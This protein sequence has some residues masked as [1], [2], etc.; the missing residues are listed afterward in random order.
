M[1]KWNS[2]WTFSPSLWVKTR[3]EL[4]QGSILPST[5]LCALKLREGSFLIKPVFQYEIRT[6]V[7][8]RKIAKPIKLLLNLDRI[9]SLLE[10]VVF[11]KP[12]AVSFLP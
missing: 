7:L 2:P 8:G 3:L 5:F 12:Y 6:R 11:S 9:G 10:S 1:L 4:D